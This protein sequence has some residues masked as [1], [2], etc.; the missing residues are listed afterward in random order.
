MARTSKP[1]FAPKRFGYGAA[2]PISWEGWAL[3]LV[4]LS[5]LAAV[6]VLL[7]G[8]LR[9]LGVCALLVAV[10]ALAAAKTDGGWRWRSSKDH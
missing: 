10:I 2:F 9:A 6:V 1:W 7:N 3:L 5:A 4:F 8:A